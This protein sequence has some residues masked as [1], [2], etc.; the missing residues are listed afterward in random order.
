MKHEIAKYSVHP[1]ALS[2]IY[3]ASLFKIPPVK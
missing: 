1:N 3:D 2:A